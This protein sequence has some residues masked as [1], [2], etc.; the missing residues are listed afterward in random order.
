M[1][2]QKTISR[3]KQHIEDWEI[4]F[5]HLHHATRD[6]GMAA[7]TQKLEDDFNSLKSD[8]QDVLSKEVDASSEDSVKE[9]NGRSKEFGLKLSSFYKVINFKLKDLAVD[10]KTS[11]ILPFA[12]T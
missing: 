6:N 2:L 8:L 5:P 10:V 3:I 1:T 4:I 12:E 9:A 11:R 7:A